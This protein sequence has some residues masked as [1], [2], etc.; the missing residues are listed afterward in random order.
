MAPHFILI[1]LE[2]QHLHLLARNLL[3]L[4]I[5]LL[6]PVVLLKAKHHVLVRLPELF[7]HLLHIAPLLALELVHL[8][9]QRLELAAQVQARFF[10]SF[11]RV[12]RARLAVL[13][14]LLGEGPQ[15]VEPSVYIP[16]IKLSGSLQMRQLL[17]DFEKLVGVHERR[18]RVHVEGLRVDEGLELS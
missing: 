11:L 17:L 7:V 10:H 18:G 16:Q 8:L 5:V 1:V 12:L 9:P 3:L 4:A 15:D 2:R 6:H 13:L 14:Q